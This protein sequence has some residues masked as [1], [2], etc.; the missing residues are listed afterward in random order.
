MNFP[1]TTSIHRPEKTKKGS[2]KSQMR[3]FLA[4]ILI[5]SLLSVHTAFAATLPAS[6]TTIEDEAFYGTNLDVVYIPEGVTS[7]G[8]NAFKNC[9]LKRAVLP[10]TVTS[11]GSGAFSGE[12]SGFFAM[13]P[14]NS[15]AMAWCR[16]NGVIYLPYTGEMPTPTPQPTATPSP[17]AAPTATMTP[18]P[19]ATPVPTP[20]SIVTTAPTVTPSPT[21]APSTPTV[22]A[23]KVSLMGDKYLGRTYSQMDCQAF[24][25]QCLADAGLPVDLTGSNAWYRTMTWVGTPEECRAKF[26][27]IPV[28]AFLYILEQNGKEPNQYKA[29][30]LGNAS[31]IGIYI[32][33]NSGAIHS[34]YSR[35]GVYYSYFAG[36]TING[37]WNRVGLWTE[38][39][40]GETVNEMLRQLG[41]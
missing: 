27:S 5:L 24:V 37:G 10:K 11:I 13:V 41:N 4:V 29:D 3:K 39:D 18:A 23:Q 34:S 31:H 2:M 35:G 33:R 25:E 12:A 40:Y 30:G 16:L 20:T 32:G 26:G 36:S 14:S 28:G 15:Y 17:T 22:S 7:I 9:G 6:L 21:P 19:T 1:S 8:A 38:L